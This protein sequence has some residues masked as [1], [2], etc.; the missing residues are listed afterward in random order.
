MFGT[1]HGCGEALRS[2]SFLSMPITHFEQLETIFPGDNYIDV[3][4]IGE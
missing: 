3:L 4:E 1:N 2:E